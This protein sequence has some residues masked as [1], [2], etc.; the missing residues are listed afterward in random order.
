MSDFNLLLEFDS[1]GVLCGFDKINFS[2]ENPIITKTSSGEIIQYG[3]FFD[4]EKY[5]GEFD[6]NIH[7]NNFRLVNGEVKELDMQEAKAY[8]NILN[9][10]NSK[11]NDLYKYWNGFKS[12]KLFYNQF[13]EKEIEISADGVETL[14]TLISLSKELNC[15][16]HCIWITKSG[17][18][19]YIKTDTVNDF[20]KKI[21]LYRM[22]FS[23][24]KEKHYNLIN[25]LITLDSITNYDVT[26][27]LTGNNFSSV[28]DVDLNTLLV[29][30]LDVIKD[31][32]QSNLDIVY[33]SCKAIN[34]HAEDKDFLLNW[35]DYKDLI[36]NQLSLAEIAKQDEKLYSFVLK[37]K[38]N[39]QV[40]S[41]TSDY[42]NPSSVLLDACKVY[43]SLIY[44]V[45]VELLK[46]NYQI[47]QDYVRKINS[48]ISLSE[49]PNILG[50]L[51]S[52][53]GFVGSLDLSDQYLINLSRN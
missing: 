30:E 14:Q 41:I 25:S 52:K 37:T 19:I 4:S 43:R 46:I 7:K 35:S 45:E 3:V 16:N 42:S 50:D 1:N 23:V 40:F 38:M 9:S 26:V 32:L 51:N 53:V 34:Y 39:Q 47:Y 27:D 18:K 29:S 11:I 12:Y 17:D 48:I 5:C 2:G 24:N 28:E 10:R 31:K 36:A 20:I 13:L 33:N 22:I 21:S 49:V 44:K 8:R 6:I 15:P